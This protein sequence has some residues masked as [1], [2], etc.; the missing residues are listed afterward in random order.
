MRIFVAVGVPKD[1]VEEVKKAQKSLKDAKLKLVKDFHVT[2]KFLGEV[3]EPKVE[4]IK[5]A[6][7]QIKLKPF[8]A[9]LTGMGVFPNPNYIRVVWIGVSPNEFIELQK[10]VNIAL[11][12]VGF[13]KDKRFHPHLTLARIKFVKDKESFKSVL[14]DIKVE[15][16][17]FEINEFKLIKST[18]TREGPVYEDL[19]VFKL[20]S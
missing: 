7:K 11:E 14:R 15:K 3:P 10:Q 13:K 9:K 17:E 5:E 8:K 19:E 4:E 20:G 2:L 16:K 6:L 12:R 1:V 18:L